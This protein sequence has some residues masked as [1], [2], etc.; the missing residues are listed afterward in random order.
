MDKLFIIVEGYG[1]AGENN[2]FFASP[3]T[4]LIQSNGKNVLI[5]PGADK[6]KLL[7]GLTSKGINIEDIDMIYL[8][9]WHPDHVL[10]IR[11]FPNV[12]IIDAGTIWKDSGEELFFDP[13]TIPGTNIEIVKTPGHTL[14]HT[15][16]LVH[17]EDK[18][19][20]VIAQDVFWWE[21]GNQKTDDYEQL[22][23]QEDP[24]MAD[25][26]QLKDS[27]KKLLQIAD[28]IIPGHGKM[29]R[30]EFKDQR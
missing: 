21:D 14:D 11:I 27:R 17:T 12:D 22:V 6:Q 30:N 20:V 3:T 19:D 8:T 28:W 15:S 1:Y 4:T 24:F 23:N 7:D 26:E 29:F 2:N 18:G 16:L 10:N 5:D 9:H 25:F 13:T